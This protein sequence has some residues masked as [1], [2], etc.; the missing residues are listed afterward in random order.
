MG[1]YGTHY[2]K[3]MFLCTYWKTIGKHWLSV[4]TYENNNENAG[5]PWEPMENVRKTQ[6][7]HRNLLKTVRI[8]Y[9]SVGTYENTR[10][11]QV[12]RGDLLKTI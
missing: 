9:F 10:K 3:H 1:T 8:H 5:F 7:F 11:T 6:V 2:E 4:G 12:F